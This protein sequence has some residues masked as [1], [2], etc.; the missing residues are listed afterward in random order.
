[1]KPIVGI[2]CL[3]YKWKNLPEAFERCASEFGLD[4]IEFSYSKAVC[5]TDLSLIEKLNKRYHLKL[6]LHVWDDMPNLGEKIGYQKM[7]DSLDVCRKMGASS[8]TIHLGTHP[9]KEE[10][11]R[12]AA[13]VF[14]RSAIL[15]EKSHIDICLENHYPYDYKNM[16]DLGGTLSEFLFIFNKVCSPALKFCLDYGHANMSNN[17]L[18]FIQ[19]LHPYLGLVHI[20]DNHGLADEHLPWPQVLPG[21]I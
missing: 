1:M 14:G 10:G 13:G 17:T 7:L 9:D 5:N 11:L 15:Y 12:I 6:S 3:Y 21:I 19:K 4:A 2:S 20:A 8:L 16:N 18:E